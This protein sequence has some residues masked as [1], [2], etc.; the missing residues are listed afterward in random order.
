MAKLQ[1]LGIFSSNEEAQELFRYGE[2]RVS[3]GLVIP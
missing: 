1:F 2:Q 3:G